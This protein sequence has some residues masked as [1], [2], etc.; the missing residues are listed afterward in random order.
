MTSRRICVQIA[1]V[2]HLL[3]KDGLGLTTETLL[4]PVVTSPALSALALLGLLVL[5]HLVQLVALA[6][7]AQTV[8]K[9]T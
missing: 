8:K 1:T 2:A 6:L 5:R 7:F 9:F 4:F 3:P